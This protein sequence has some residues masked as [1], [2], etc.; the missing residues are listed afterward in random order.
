M[1]P[2]H[3]VGLCRLQATEGVQETLQ[4][5]PEAG[6]AHRGVQHLVHR[7]IEIYVTVYLVTRKQ[8]ERP[9]G[10]SEL[11]HWRM[12]GP[13]VPPDITPHSTW[14]VSRDVTRRDITCTTSTMRA[15]PYPL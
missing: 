15:R 13:Q 6:P 12:L 4:P 11:P 14:H 7:Y 9:P 8:W 1:V 5:L 10:E 3:L 2:C